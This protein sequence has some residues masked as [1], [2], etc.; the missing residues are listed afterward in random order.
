MSQPDKEEYIDNILDVFGKMRA[1]LYEHTPGPSRDMF[2]LYNELCA[3]PPSE[4]PARDAAL[5]TRLQ[6]CID[7]FSLI[8]KRLKASYKPSKVPM[9][10]RL[11]IPAAMS[12]MSEH[13]NYF[14][15]AGNS[16]MKY[17]DTKDRAHLAHAAETLKPFTV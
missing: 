7:S 2:A 8:G 12:K 4:L 10:L 1:L 9:N 11:T 16:L 17:L 13:I 3:L 14:I 5:R 6:T 15:I